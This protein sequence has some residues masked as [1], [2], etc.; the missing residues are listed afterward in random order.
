MPK[1]NPYLMLNGN[2]KE[3]LQFYQS[4]LGG[5]LQLMTYGD[6]QGEGCPLGMKDQL[7]HG[8]LKSGDFMLMAT[9]TVPEMKSTFGQSVQLSL[10]CTSVE[11]IERLYSAL[12][13]GGQQ[14]YP[15]HDAF[16][17]AK[18]GALVDKFGIYWMLDC[19]K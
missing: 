13:E 18:F 5:E 9:D 3:A 17:G 4:C 11:E 7:I 16:W 1:L 6:T 14:L 19:P 2:S 8:A 15:L 10:S 12:S